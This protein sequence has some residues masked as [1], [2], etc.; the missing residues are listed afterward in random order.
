MSCHLRQG[1]T[2]TLV[3]GALK[4]TLMMTTMFILIFMEVGFQSPSVK[5]RHLYDMKC[6]CILGTE[7]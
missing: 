1:Q 2:G 5:Q 3:V 7:T 4:G 6:G